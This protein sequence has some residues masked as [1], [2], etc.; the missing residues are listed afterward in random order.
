[1]TVS[2]VDGTELALGRGA[3]MW[4]P[5]SDPDVVL[6]PDT[7]GRVRAFGATVGTD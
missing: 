6:T 2:S 4:L 3:A 1:M 5:A 7:S